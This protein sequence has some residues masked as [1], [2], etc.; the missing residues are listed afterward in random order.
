MYK[1]NLG[2]LIVHL[3]ISQIGA[4]LYF[5]MDVLGMCGAKDQ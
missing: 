2:M 1:L 3:G 5:V 4:I